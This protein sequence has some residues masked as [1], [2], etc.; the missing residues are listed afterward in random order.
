MKI[1]AQ[2]GAFLRALQ[3]Y[4]IVSRETLLS[5]RSLKPYK[6]PDCGAVCIVVGLIDFQEQFLERGD[7][8]SMARFVAE[9]DRGCKI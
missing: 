1:I 7:G 4:Q 3:S 5:G 9:G 6:A 8:A 2:T